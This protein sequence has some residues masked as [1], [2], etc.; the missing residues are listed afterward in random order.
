MTRLDQL[1]ALVVKMAPGPWDGEDGFVRAGNGRPIRERADVAAI[2]ALRNNADA[3]LAAL[4]A[5]ID[6]G[7][8][9]DENVLVTVDR[10]RMTALQRALAP[11]RE[12]VEP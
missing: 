12:E 3:L 4:R 2:V 8:Y 1:A 6:L 9:G 5:A 11:F 10:R 7:R